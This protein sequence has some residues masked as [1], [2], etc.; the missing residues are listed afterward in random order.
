MQLKSRAFENGGTIPDR[1]SCEG[2]DV[3]PPLSWTGVPPAAEALALI[4]EDPDAPLK[5]FTHWVLYDLPAHAS[6]LPEGISKNPVVIGE[7]KQ[8]TNS[9]GRLG[10]DGPCPPTGPFHRYF[11][12][13]YALDRPLHLKNGAH[14]KELENAME[15]HVLAEAQMVGRYRKVK[16]G[17]LV[18]A[19][20]GH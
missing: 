11:F 15:G 9:Y 13:L 10:Y 5:T 1:F 8:G 3:S 19:L 18:H 14:K 7:A 4:C 2:D 20:R 17:P 6:G 12:K 16:L